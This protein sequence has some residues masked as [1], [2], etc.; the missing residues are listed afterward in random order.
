MAQ[1]V[2]FTIETAAPDSAIFLQ[3]EPLTST[4]GC[5]GYVLVTGT[6]FAAFGSSPFLLSLEDGFAWSVAIV[7][8]WA[9]AFAVRALIRA[10]N[11]ADNATTDE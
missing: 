6:E 11:A 7:G 3:L 4:G 2:A 8:V 1:C 9:A 10:L 5:P